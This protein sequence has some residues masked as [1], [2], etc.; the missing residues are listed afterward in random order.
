MIKKGDSKTIQPGRKVCYLGIMKG[1]K[2]SGDEANKWPVSC[3]TNGCIFR[4]DVGEL[5]ERK[6]IR[7]CSF[8][9]LWR[10][11]SHADF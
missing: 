6:D 1:K 8:H 9:L 2:E 5:W 3:I 11:E 10:T 4:A 7:F